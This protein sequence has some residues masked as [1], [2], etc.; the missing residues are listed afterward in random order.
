MPTFGDDIFF[1][2]SGEIVTRLKAGEFSSKDLTR[3]FLKRLETLGA[4]YRALVLPLDKDA[5][6]YA[7]DVDSDIKIERYRGP[8]QGVPYAVADVFSV[9]SRPTTWGSGVFAGQVFDFDATVVSKLQDPYAVLLGKLA[10]MELAGCGGYRSTAASAT[11]A[12]RNPWDPERWTG[13][14]SSGPAAAV[15]AGLATFALGPAAGDSLLA[16]CAFCGITGLRPSYGLVSRYGAIPSSWTMAATGVMARSVKDCALVLQQISG[17]DLMD[18]SSAGKSYYYFPQFS[19]PP[20]KLRLGYAPAD[21]DAWPAERERAVFREALG[22][23]RELG[24]QLTEWKLPDFPYLS[25]ARVIS[26]AEGSA[27]FEDLITGRK[28]EQ[29]ADPY[30]IAGM[31]AGLEIQARDYLRAMRVRSLIR[32]AYYKLFVDVDVLIAPTRYSIA[33]PIGEPVKDPTPAAPSADPGMSELADA[34]SLAGLPALTMPCGFAGGLPL[35]ISLTGRAFTE[36]TLVSLGEAFQA[37]TAWH[38][39]RPPMDRN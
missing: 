1:A 31:K 16:P 2:S 7:G 11:G 13:G 27:A 30:Q 34:G 35:G 18:A 29:L 33:P 32:E 36:N 6:E 10:V 26:Q 28:V 12:C 20:E 24:A 17:G 37:R 38:K 19:R 3:A 22:V 14:A 23:F 21:F 25:V 8:L 5:D 9:A 15:A 39:R 4:R